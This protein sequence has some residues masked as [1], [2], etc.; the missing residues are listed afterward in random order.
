M[1]LEIEG[2]KIIVKLTRQ[3]IFQMGHGR[4]FEGDNFKIGLEVK[5]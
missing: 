2:K 5:I 3:E 1:K 4:I